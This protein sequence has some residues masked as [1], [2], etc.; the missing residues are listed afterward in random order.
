[1]KLTSLLNELDF[2]NQAAFDKYNSTHKV[3][4]S[5][6][7]TI[8]GKTTTAGEAEKKTTKKAEPKKAEPKKDNKKDAEKGILSTIGSFVRSVVFGKP[9]DD[10]KPTTN[11]N[12]KKETK[13]IKPVKPKKDNNEPKKDKK[14]D[15]T[16]RTSWEREA[17]APYAE[18]D[19]F[20]V[21]RF[22]PGDRLAGDIT[23][24]EDFVIYRTAKIGLS[25]IDW[26]GAKD[27]KDFNYDFKPNPENGSV[28][29]S[30][31]DGPVELFMFSPNDDGK[32]NFAFVSDAGD[33]GSEFTFN[34]QNSTS[35]ADDG[36]F[37]GREGYDDPQYVYQAMRYI[38]VQPETIQ[39]LRGELTMREYLPTYNRL[40]TELEG[41]KSSK[42]NETSLKSIVNTIKK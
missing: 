1:M 36:V 26:F 16:R 39:L 17:G 33:D 27:K 12:D 31:E 6:K 30:S 38:M 7:V 15:S 4:N 9:T 40:K 18:D 42:K 35:S 41:S 25:L 2:R 23:T 10:A 3:R 14:Q 28:R 34:N 19:K 29:I 22:L 24:E 13:P 20:W 32:F 5:T 8:A 11:S 37:G 21:D